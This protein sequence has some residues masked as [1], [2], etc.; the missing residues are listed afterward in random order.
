M[1]VNDRDDAIFMAKSAEQAERYDEMVVEMNMIVKMGS[2]LSVEERNLLSVAYKNV[3]GQRRASWRIL[4]SIEQKE[5]NKG[6]DN[7][8]TA[9][10][11]YKSKIETEL[12]TIS[13]EIID[14]INTHLLPNSNEQNKYFYYRMK[15][16]YFRYL[17]ELPPN[18][19]ENAQKS[20]QSYDDATNILQS[21]FPPT[22]PMVLSHALNL[23]TQYY[24]ILNDPV[25]ACQIAKHAFDAAISELD[26][27]DE[28]E[29]KDATLLM[30]LLRDNLT[31]WTSDM[32]E[33]ADSV[34][35]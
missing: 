32:D 14:L 18:Q 12:K 1:E 9:A 34:C 2:D 22:N 21:S 15:G 30:Q 11:N 5:S 16:D 6:N 31:L 33:D 29:Y 28:S 8:A 35:K 25:K 7:K 27:L 13:N 23:S 24:E 17:S 20:R 10:H 19:S 3:I 4:S 26:T